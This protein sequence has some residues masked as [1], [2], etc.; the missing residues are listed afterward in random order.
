VIEG[1]APYVEYHSLHLYT[2]SDDYYSNV[3]APHQAERALRI[4]QGLIEQARYRQGIRHPITVAYDEWNIWYRERDPEARK[5]GA[6][7]RYNLADALAVATYLNIF[8]RHCRTVT[9]ANLAQLVNAIA[10]IFT[11]PEGLFLQTIYHPFRLYAE[12]TR[13]VALDV[14]VACETYDLTPEQETSP[15]RHRVA[16]L[17]PFKLL[18]VAATC[19]PSAR[20]LVLAVVNRDRERAVAAT[21]QLDAASVADGALAY[22]VNGRDP[23]VVNSFEEPEAVAVRERRLDVAGPRFEYEFP[24]HSATVLRLPLA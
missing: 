8:I 23:H 14:H 7:E 9:I 19:D 21:V 16:D 15:L 17:G 1:L 6:E 11:N 13:E 18:D 4:T 24:A 3:F 12:H 20:E 22:E 10:A 5:R 2:G